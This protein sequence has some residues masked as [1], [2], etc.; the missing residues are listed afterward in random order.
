MRGLWKMGAVAL[1]AVAVGGSVSLAQPAAL[2]KDLAETPPF[3]S[4]WFGDSDKPAKLEGKE[5]KD[6]TPRGA[7][8]RLRAS[9]RAAEGAAKGERYENLQQRLRPPTGGDRQVARGR[10]GHER[11]GPRRRGG[12]ASRRWPSGSSGRS[13]ARSRAS[14]RPSRSPTRSTRV[15]A[16]QAV[17]GASPPG[18]RRGSRHDPGIPG[19]CGPI[20]WG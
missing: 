18:S 16:S 7:V 10:R 17:R 2:K 8:R 4:G 5:P 3:W 9:A 20:A 15:T 11:P 19:A 12:C 6:E 13:P 14:P 1:A